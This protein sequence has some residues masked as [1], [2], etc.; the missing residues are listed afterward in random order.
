MVIVGGVF[1]S[2]VDPESTLG[3]LITGLLYLYPYVSIASIVAS[4]TCPRFILVFPD[5]VPLDPNVVSLS[6]FPFAV[7][8]IFSMILF[9]F[10]LISMRLSFPS[11]T[12]L[13][14]SITF[15]SEAGRIQ[16]S[17]FISNAPVPLLYLREAERYP[18]YHSGS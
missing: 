13:M 14:L 3:L 11:P 17:F 12:G 15:H 6:I 16:G 2:V 4:N 1:V 10:H 5:I 7:A 18:E 8:R 9:P